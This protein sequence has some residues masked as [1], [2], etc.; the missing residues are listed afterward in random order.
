VLRGCGASEPDL[1]VKPIP[2]VA[3]DSVNLNPI[4]WPLAEGM[5]P[6]GRGCQL[7]VEQKITALAAAVERALALLSNERPTPTTDELWSSAAPR[8]LRQHDRY[9]FE[10]RGSP[11]GGGKEVKL[12]RDT[13]WARLV[14]RKNEHVLRELPE[15]FLRAVL[16]AHCPERAS[17][18]DAPARVLLEEARLELFRAT[19]YYAQAY[20]EE[21]HDGD[22]SPAYRSPREKD[23]ERISND[24]SA[25][26]ADRLKAANELAAIAAKRIADNR[27]KESEYR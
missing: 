6:R 19:P 11:Y 25:S 8:I 21:E 24:P 10:F 18:L 1:Y 5:V 3:S 20:A 27:S 23:L 22:Y 17:R 9:E 12:Q 4:L 2:Q 13:P 7:R 16:T 14:R 15:P 26:Q